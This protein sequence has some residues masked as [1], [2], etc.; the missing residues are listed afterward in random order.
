MTFLN[1]NKERYYLISY[2][3]AGGSGSIWFNYKGFPS[4]TWIKKTIVKT[5]AISKPP[6][7][8]NIYEFNNKQDYQDF[9]ADE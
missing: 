9:I 6:A 3:Y 5:F 8:V 1:K 4:H 7:I 2:V